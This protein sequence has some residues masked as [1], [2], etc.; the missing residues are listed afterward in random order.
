MHSQSTQQKSYAQ[1]NDF[2][3]TV[4]FWCLNPAVAFYYLKSCHSVILTSGTLSPMETFQSELGVRF[5]HQLEACHV[6]SDKQVWVGSLGY[7]P[8][9]VNLLTNYKTCETFAYQDELGRLILDVCKVI[10]KRKLS[11]LFDIDCIKP[12]TRLFRTVCCVF[13]HPTRF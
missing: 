6:I 13:Y 3:Y 9:D 4:N 10:I 2:N 11:C 12:Y 8:T 5:D 7:G 1:K